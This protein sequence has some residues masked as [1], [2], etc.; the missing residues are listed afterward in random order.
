MSIETIKESPGVP[1]VRTVKGRNQFSIAFS[2]LRGKKLGMIALTAIAAL[3][4]DLV[5]LPALLQMRRTAR[6]PD[7]PRKRTAP[8]GT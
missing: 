5:F 1:K 2:R 6:A 8:A 7:A 3:L 4:C